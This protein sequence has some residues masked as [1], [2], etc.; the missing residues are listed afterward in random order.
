[1]KETTTM[2]ISVIYDEKKGFYYP[3]TFS[4]NGY[5]VNYSSPFTLE[6]VKNQG[7]WVNQKEEDNYNERNHTTHT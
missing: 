6:E 2:G 7:W 5:F 4:D 3:V 1:M